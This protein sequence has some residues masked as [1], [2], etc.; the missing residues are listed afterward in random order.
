MKDDEKNKEDQDIKVRCKS[1][2]PDEWEAYLKS[3]ETPRTEE[4]LSN[5]N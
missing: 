2:T 5:S 3:I 1:W 4:I